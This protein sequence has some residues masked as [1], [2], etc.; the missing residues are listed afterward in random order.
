M[1]LSSEANR[2]NSSLAKCFENSFL[3][4]FDADDRNFYALLD[5]QGTFLDVNQRFE[6]HFS[7]SKKQILGTHLS[8][9]FRILDND[10]SAVE[11]IQRVADGEL[12]RS[13]LTL[14]EDAL[15]LEV[16]CMRVTLGS[17]NEAEGRFAIVLSGHDITAIKNTERSLRQL[18]HL[19]PL[20]Q[21]PNLRFIDYQLRK[22]Q[23]QGHREGRGFTVVFIDFDQFK[24]INDVHGHLAGD[25]VLI[26]FSRRLRSRLRGGEHVGR[27]GGVE[28]LVVIRE[29]LCE[30]S[31]LALTERLKNVVSTPFDLG[32]N[33]QVELS[34]SVG[35]SVWPN[36]GDSLLE[37]KRLADSRMYA[38]KQRP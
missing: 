8:S 9:F 14:E 37:L 30:R 13:Q 33:S 5:S 2:D 10:L 18:A 21:L 36:D 15:C 12:V 27:I 29:A 19:D 23:A 22:L 1:L 32:E 26:E 4:L 24:A 3:S 28:F 35:I 7:C 6:R 31:C 17:S 16:S 25:Q 11:I 34:I 38:D 20:T